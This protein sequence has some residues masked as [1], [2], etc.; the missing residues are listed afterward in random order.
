ME[1]DEGKVKRFHGRK[2]VPKTFFHEEDDERTG[3]SQG[4]GKLVK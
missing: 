2:K 1:G 3:D 4:E